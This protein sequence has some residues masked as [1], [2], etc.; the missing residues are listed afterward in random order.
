LYLGGR[1]FDSGGRDFDLEGRDFDSGGRD[2]RLGGRDFDLERYKNWLFPMDFL[3]SR[4]PPLRKF[5]N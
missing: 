5:I 3:Q 4:E 2:F 1:D